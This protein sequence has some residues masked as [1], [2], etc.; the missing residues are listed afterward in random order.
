MDKYNED[1]MIRNRYST[2]KIIEML[3]DA[4]VALA[5]GMTVVKVSRK[6]SITEQAYYR[7]RKQYGGLK[8]S[9]VMR[10][11]IERDNT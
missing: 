9:R 1:R 6:L 7:L 5:Q 2:D 4:V 3:W 8:I 10:I 11:Q